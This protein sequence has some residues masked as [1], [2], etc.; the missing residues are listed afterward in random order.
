MNIII[1]RNTSKLPWRIDLS[2]GRGRVLLVS[3]A[4]LCVAVLLGLGAL[5]GVWLGSPHAREMRMLAALHAALDSQRGE[6]DALGSHSR[7]N[8]DALS[9][10]LGQLQAQATRLNALG[11]RLTEMG[12]LGDGEFD[13]SDAPAMGGPEEAGGSAAAPLPLQE[14]IDRLRLTFDDQQTQLD[15]LDRLLRDQKIE[16]ALLPTGMPVAQGYVSSGFGGR[17]DPF[18]GHQASHL[19]VDFSAPAGSPVM[20]VADGV[21]TF[22]G[23]RSGYG[24]VV[25]IDHGNGYMTRYAHASKIDVAPGARVHAG[26]VIANVGSTGR[27][28]GPHCHFEVWRDGRAVNPMRYV[29]N[30]REARA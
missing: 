8:L 19:G 11:E 29:Q 6:L 2:A 23:E 16:S 26:Q 10:Q 12:K 18:D 3:A 4:S 9:L 13:F 7:R 30:V 20:A 1:V 14:S 24:N 17:S 25:E 21:V 28:T 5:I 22:A 27:S 15:M